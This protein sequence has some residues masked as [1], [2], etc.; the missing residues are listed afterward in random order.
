MYNLPESVFYE[1]GE[2]WDKE[3]QK[4]IAKAIESTIDEAK[5]SDLKQCQSVAKEL[6]KDRKRFNFDRPFYQI[7]KAFRLTGCHLTITDSKG[8]KITQIV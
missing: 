7:N 3:F 6:I 1:N 5:L 4:V 8:N 2:V